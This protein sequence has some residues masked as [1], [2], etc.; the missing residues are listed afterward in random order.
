MSVASNPLTTTPTATPPP[1][2]Q[3]QQFPP[4]RP[5][6]AIMESR[7]LSQ[8]P[9]AAVDGLPHLSQDTLHRRTCPFSG[10]LYHPLRGIAYVNYS[11]RV[12]SRLLVLTSIEH[13]CVPSP[14]FQ[15]GTFQR[16]TIGLASFLDSCLDRPG[17][18]AA[19]P[20]PSL[21][22]GLVPLNRSRIS[23]RLKRKLET[24]FWHK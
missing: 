7:S 14:P 15:V 19:S 24:R 8:S 5:P 6:P 4:T 22:S 21:E 11:Q 2:H 1:Q 23:P 16:D 18:R 3:S 17:S 12:Y 20:Q 9:Q 10:P 13:H